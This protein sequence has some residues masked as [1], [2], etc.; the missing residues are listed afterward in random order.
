[1]S[2][3]HKTLVTLVFNVYN[4]VIFYFSFI[5]LLIILSRI[6]IKICTK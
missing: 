2:V 4:P 1:M 5:N 3:V 6:M